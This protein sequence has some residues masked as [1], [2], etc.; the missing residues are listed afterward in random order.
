M[1]IAAKDI[2][3]PKDNDMSWG[4]YSFSPAIMHTESTSVMINIYDAFGH[5]FFEDDIQI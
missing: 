1:D 3:L 4:L 5:F 2:G